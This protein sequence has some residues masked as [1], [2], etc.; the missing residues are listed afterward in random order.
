[1]PTLQ[2]LK[3]K[4]FIDLTAEE[5]F[6]P[7]TR[8]KGALVSAYTDG[9]QLEPLIDGAALMAEFH[10][11]LEMM[12]NSEDPS[13]WTLFISAMNIQPVKL[14]GETNP[15]KDAMAKILDAAEAGVKVYYLG[16]GHAGADQ[17]SASFAKKLMKYGSEGT[18]DKRFPPYAGQHQKFTVAH[19]PDNTW[20]GTL[21]SADFFKTNWDTPDHLDENPDRAK[22]AGPI[23]NASLKVQGPAVH[24]IALTFA[25]RWNDDTRDRTAPPISSAI[26]TSFLNTPIPTQGTHSVQLLRNYGIESKAGESYSWADHGE[27]TVW[28]SY[29]NAIKRAERYVY[30]EDQYLYPFR[31][32]PVLEHDDDQARFA[33]IYFQ[34]GEALKR[35]VDVICLVPGRDDAFYKHYEFQHRG[36]GAEYLNH[37]SEEH[38]GAGR[39]IFSKLRVGKKDPVVHAKVMLVDDELALVGSTNIAL[40]SM[41]LCSEIHM[42]VIDEQNEFVRDLR[43]KLWGEH[44]ALDDFEP[45]LDPVEAVDAYRQNAESKVGHLRLLPVERLD[46]YIPYGRVWDSVIDPYRGPDPDK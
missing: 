24:D 18:G 13:Q 22:G 23:H 4:W 11:Q 5:K 36:I 9:N 6:P 35:G 37:I 2:E 39:F 17:V 44:M 3:D 30:I 41:A 16:S 32:D 21:G 19:G 1:M 28:A 25:E 14:L 27:F 20:L 8:H 43:L 38:P 33:D 10:D 40:R 12:I 34:M 42:A 31:F 26:D 29:L 46:L 45:I 15:A 7:Q